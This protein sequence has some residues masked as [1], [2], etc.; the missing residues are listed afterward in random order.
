M[1][2]SGFPAEIRLRTS[3]LAAVIVA[4]AVLLPSAGVTS[5]WIS[6]LLLAGVAGSAW[7]WIGGS[8]ARRAESRGRSVTAA[9]EALARGELGFDT[10]ECEEFLASLAALQE[11][12]R[13]LGGAAEALAAGRPVQAEPRSDRDLAGKGLAAAG[14]ALRRFAEG[15]RRVAHG[16]A[17]AGKDT[18]QP[19]G[20]Y[21][22]I[23]GEF[24]ECRLTMVQA[25]ARVVEA[26]QAIARGEAP[27][28]SAPVGGRE[29]GEIEQSIHSAADSM[30]GL[31]ECIHIMQRMAVNDYTQKVTGNYPGI[32]KSLADS[33]NEMRRRTLSV[34]EILEHVANG[35]Y[36]AD[37]AAIVR[38]GKASEHDTYRPT[39]IRMMQSIDTLALDAQTLFQ[40]AV[41][42]RLSVR[43]DV[44]RH[45]GQ[46][47]NIMQGVNDILDAVIAP[48]QEAGSVLRRIA[49]GDLTVRVTG[50]YNGDHA[51]IQAHINAMADHLAASLR[52]IETSTGQLT[53]S[54]KQLQAVSG[55]LSESA[56][57]TATQAQGASSADEQVSQSTN[58]VASSTE[59]MSASI[60]EI[61]HNAAQSAKIAQTATLK[62][63]AANA[64]VARLGASS[65]EIGDVLKVIT[66]IA[67][68]TNLLALNATIEAA[69]AGEA[70][71]GFAVVANEVKE[72]AKET[73][74]AT[75]DIGHRIESV[76]QET[77]GAISAISEIT[78]I[79]TEVSGISGTIAS[80]VEEQTA[81]TNEMS[82]N[83]AEAAR[84]AAQISGNIRAVAEAASHTS[85]GASRTQAAATELSQ[86]ATSLERLVRQFRFDGTAVAEGGPRRAMAARPA[87]SRVQ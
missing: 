53:A 40:A 17:G 84:G 28:R 66:T 21:G 2:K 46:F 74:K 76:Q 41:E 77:S 11:Y 18:A 29:S 67:Q 71:K 65:A 38:R 48:M 7:F 4:T 87:S 25:T 1:H 59:Q 30:Q 81:T 60:R 3:I 26:L 34:I 79:I 63:Q 55:E 22:E 35:D 27:E 33:T 69:R 24:A 70:G 73:A 13:A 19:P 62:A 14:E 58:T 49:E 12:L 42:G 37:L 10:R 6:A 16:E 86:M 5:A 72:L 31:A 23:L 78:E 50:N 75:E 8:I 9:L 83:I 20:V 54:S 64:T 61:A 15:A 85:E 52:S 51:A 80:A 39:T 47:R 36:A 68:Q 57:R 45:Q 32:F 56:E 44:A 43:G 82:R